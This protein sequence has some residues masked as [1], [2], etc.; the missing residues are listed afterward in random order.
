M[1]ETGIESRIYT[2]NLSK[3][4]AGSRRKRAGK[5]MRIL[6]QELEKRGEEN[7]K[8]DNAVNHKIWE[9]GVSKPPKKIEVE[10][11]DRG[12]QSWV[13]LPE[14]AV[15]TTTEEEVESKTEV[16]VAGSTV[17]E[18]K[19]AVRQGELEAETALE[20]EKDSKNRKSLVSWLEKRLGES[21][22]EEETESGL[23][24]EVTSV[25]ADGSIDEGKEAL[26]ELPHSDFER[27]LDFEEAHQNRKGM[28]KFI[29]SNMR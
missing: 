18:V 20:Q 25:L 19:Q 6:K 21:E 13:S 29:E 17:K 1:A 27:A 23:P 12:Q 24:E 9:R 15:P 28:K 3:A 10:V 4:K 8:I 26:K 7:L 11:T 16:E 2:I 5:A 22:E 14:E